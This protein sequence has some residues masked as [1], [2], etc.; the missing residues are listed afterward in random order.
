MKLQHPFAGLMVAPPGAVGSK[1]Q[2]ADPVADL[3]TL[4][5]VQFV[6]QGGKVI[7]ESR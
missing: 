5:D 2:A 4:R 6:M 7:R 3:Q 1:S